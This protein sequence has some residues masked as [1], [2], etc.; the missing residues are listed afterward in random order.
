MK[1]G[2]RVHEE[3][4]GQRLSE[5][6]GLDNRSLSG[7][8][9][10]LVASHARERQIPASHVVS[11]MLSPSYMHWSRVLD[12]LF[13]GHTRFYRHPRVWEFLANEVRLFSPPI[14]ALVAGCST[15]Q[16]AITLGLMLD[17]AAAGRPFEIIAVDA[18]E[19][20]LEKARRGRYAVRDISAIPPA[21]AQKGFDVSSGRDAVVAPWL[22]GRIQYQWC[23]LLQ[24]LPPGPFR[25]VL[26]RNVLTY[27]TPASVE[28]VLQHVASVLSPDGLFV[29]APQE[30]HLIAGSRGFAA[31]TPGL[32][33]YRLAHAPL[34]ATV[35]LPEPRC[36]RSLLTG[37]PA[38]PHAPTPQRLLPDAP[39]RVCATAV[40]L[41]LGS[42]AW[43]AVE[44]E[45]LRYLEAPPGHLSLDLTAVHHIDSHVQ[46][47]LQAL[48]RL[49]VCSGT[50]LRLE[51]AAPSLAQWG[52]G[53]FTP[54][55]REESHV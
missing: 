41:D 30:T 27:M 20:A 32:P 14:R 54:S 21:W 24:G 25:L 36:L 4:L 3:A 8:I 44:A 43:H 7:P 33:I 11:E 39:P 22:M 29:V 31:V 38:A 51:G 19:A 40:S 16:E 42:E 53:R 55:D 34:V 23:N 12:G 15:G 5:S 17:A 37:S 48:C 9:R 47:R 35:G 6:Y 45:L 18:N 13:L 49:L 2:E 10:E 50:S 28:T 52:L 1:Q 46:R 26:L